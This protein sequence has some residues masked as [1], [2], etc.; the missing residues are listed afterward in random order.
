[1]HVRNF[2]GLLLLF[3]KA[4]LSVE[5]RIEPAVFGNLGAI[6]MLNAAK[7]YLQNLDEIEVDGDGLSVLRRKVPDQFRHVAQ[8]GQDHY[9]FYILKFPPEWNG[10]TIPTKTRFEI[11]SSKEEIDLTGTVE[12]LPENCFK[13]GR[14]FNNLKNE[15]EGSG[16]KLKLRIHESD[17]LVELYVDERFFLT[18]VNGFECIAIVSGDSI[19]SFDQMFAWYSDWAKALGFRRVFQG[20]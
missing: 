13:D 7:G 20:W 9:F 16:M 5:V 8:E 10:R 18:R 17:S 3:S 2:A 6:T 4:A 15:F 19:R 11:I 1:M 14:T 12:V